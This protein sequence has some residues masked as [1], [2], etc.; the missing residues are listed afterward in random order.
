[1]GQMTTDRVAMQ[2]LQEQ[3]PHSDPRR[4]HAVGP[5]GIANLATHCKNGVRLQQSVPHSFVHCYQIV[6]ILGTIGVLPGPESF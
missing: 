3:Y 6:V 4:Q 1:M 5:V 2:R